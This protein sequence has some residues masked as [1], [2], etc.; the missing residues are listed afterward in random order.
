M[1]SPLFGR[2]WWWC[3]PTY[4]GAPGCRTGSR[5]DAAP[6][7]GPERCDIPVEG[8]YNSRLALAARIFISRRVRLLQ[9][10]QP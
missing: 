8:A 10:A 2:V 3:V 6:L 1:P 4:S 9:E 7:D 5:L